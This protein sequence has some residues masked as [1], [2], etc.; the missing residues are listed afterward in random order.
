MFSEVVIINV[1]R[2]Q[3]GIVR[4]GRLNRTIILL[5]D[6]EDGFTGQVPVHEVRGVE[7]DPILEILSLV[8]GFLCKYYVEAT[9]TTT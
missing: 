1:S 3:F 5:W 7:S 9:A 2:P 6:P 8:S 4:V